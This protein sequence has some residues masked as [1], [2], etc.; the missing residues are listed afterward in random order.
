M[1]GLLE[2]ADFS[3]RG[4]AGYVLL[5]CVSAVRELQGVLNWYHYGIVGSAELWA[6]QWWR[7]YGTGVGTEVRAVL[8]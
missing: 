3:V 1:V 8:K 2:C 6:M 5:G 4:Y 7:Q